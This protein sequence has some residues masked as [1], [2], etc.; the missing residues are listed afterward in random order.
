MKVKLKFFAS[1]VIITAVVGC[2]ENPVLGDNIRPQINGVKEIMDESYGLIG[3]DRDYDRV[4]VLGAERLDCL[5]NEPAVVNVSFW[6]PEL[7]LVPLNTPIVV[8]DPMAPFEV[9]SNAYKE[10][11]CFSGSPQGHGTVTFDEIE[12]ASAKGSVDIHFDNFV[13]DECTD[14]PIDNIDFFWSGF[15]IPDLEPS[16]E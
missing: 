10:G 8:D 16:C 4:L 3:G 14:K 6:I 12:Y 7:S 5:G 15:A 13:S 9:F 2:S 1:A 11:Y